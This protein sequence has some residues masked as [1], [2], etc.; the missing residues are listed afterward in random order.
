MSMKGLQGVAD[1]VRDTPSNQIYLENLRR[2][3]PNYPDRWPKYSRGSFQKQDRA[4]IKN[5]AHIPVTLRPTRII[6]P[7]ETQFYGNRTPQSITSNR[8]NKM[9]MRQSTSPYG[10]FKQFIDNIIPKT[11]MTAR[12]QFTHSL[13]QQGRPSRADFNRSDRA[14]IPSPATGGYQIPG[15]VSSALKRLTSRSVRGP[16]DSEKIVITGIH[17]TKKKVAGGKKKIAGGMKKKAKKIS[18]STAGT[19]RLNQEALARAKAFRSSRSSPAVATPAVATPAS[20]SGTPTPAV[21]TPWEKIKNRF[22]KLSPGQAAALGGAAGL[23][24]GL[25]VS[26]G[27]K[28]R[29]GG[30]YISGGYQNKTVNYYTGGANSRGW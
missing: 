20:T 15:G 28:R 2:S 27:R 1:I 16:W 25:L 24:A 4:A 11:K 12:Q 7:Y 13:S 9:T 14:S 10:Q 6:K 8:R 30:T 23:A 29:R 17:K 18:K 21:A 19:E 5:Q 26:H 3:I 22:N